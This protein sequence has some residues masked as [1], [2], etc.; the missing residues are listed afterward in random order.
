MP[1]LISVQIIFATSKEYWCKTIEIETPS[2]VKKAI[3]LSG[4]LQQFPEIDLAVNK[5]G[6][7]GE[8]VTLYH[9]VFENDRIEIYRGLIYDP[10]EL[11]KKRAKIQRKKKLL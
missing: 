2:T 10:K 9:E 11:R 5:V 1:N 4:V 6:I 7:F 8:L 3:E